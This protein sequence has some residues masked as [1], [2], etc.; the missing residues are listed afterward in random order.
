MTPASPET[1]I[2]ATLGW[3]G[4]PYHHQA[5][6]K[7]VGCDC[8]GLARG[9]WREIVGPEPLDAWGGSVPAYSRDWG[10]VSRREVLAE[11]ARAVGLIEIPVA[12]ATPGA[13]ILFRMLPKSV[14][15]HCGILVS[16]TEFVHARDGRRVMRCNYDRTWSNPRRAAFAF[17]YPAAEA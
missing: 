17:L 16:E 8:L 11:A 9:V 5:S 4:T 3:M 15:K 6:V 2:R 10:E 13:L 12:D 1:V 7:G 14:A